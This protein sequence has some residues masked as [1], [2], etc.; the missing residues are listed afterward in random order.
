ML[1]AT[2]VLLKGIGEST[3]RRLW[4]SGVGD[5]SAFRSRASLPGIA[6]LRKPLYDEELATAAEHLE[7][8]NARYFSRRLKPRDHWRLFEAFGTR[9]VFLDIETTGSPP[10]YGEVT[11]V[12]LYGNGVMTTL[13]RHDS[14]TEEHLSAELS[15]Y[16][17][18]V[19]FCGSIF[20]L[21]YLRAKFPRLTLDQPHIDLCF[22]A[23]RVGLR[24]GLKRI[25]EAL[26]LERAP[27]LQGLDG[28]DAVRLW[29][30]SR[31]GSREALDLLIGYNEA[32]TRNLLPLAQIV[33]ARLAERYGPVSAD[34]SSI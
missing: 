5:W 3:E 15:R 17:L 9:A 20:D 11:V 19:T 29:Q 14:L 24:G 21:P 8:G 6:P 32:D 33:C 22:A 7:R 1:Q 34:S 13:V 4:E 16:E 31:R 26:G 30:A 12:G 10:A 25:E 23:K 27:E 18:L 28:W 2:F